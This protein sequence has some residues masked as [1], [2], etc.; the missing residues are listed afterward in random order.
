MQ[1]KY[2]TARNQFQPSDSSDSTQFN[3][4]LAVEQ[5]P[6]THKN[7]QHY[8]QQHEKMKEYTSRD[9][10]PIC[11][12]THWCRHSP[13]AELRVIHCH[14]GAE[15]GY[16]IGQTYN[17]DGVERITRAHSSHGVL[18]FIKDGN[19]DQYYEKYKKQE[20]SM[21][22]S[23]RQKTVHEESFSAIH[24][25]NIVT[26]CQQVE[27]TE[28]ELDWAQRQ[29]GLTEADLRFSKAYPNN[30]NTIKIANDYLQQHQD[31]L[32]NSNV[33]LP[34]TIRNSKKVK[35]Y[36][37]QHGI[38]FPSFTA[39][40][41]VQSFQIRAFNPKTKDRKYEAAIHSSQ[42][43]YSVYHNNNGWLDKVAYTEGPAKALWMLKMGYKVVVALQGKGQVHAA[44]WAAA[45]VENLYG[46]SDSVIALDREDNDKSDNN[47]RKAE[48]KLAIQLSFL[49]QVS[50]LKWDNI[51]GKGI[52][53]LMRNG[54]TH[55]VEPFLRDPEDTTKALDGIQK[56]LGMRLVKQ[57]ESHH[58]FDVDRARAMQNHYFDTIARPN[59]DMEG[60]Y[61]FR[62]GAGLGKTDQLIA[63]VKY[64]IQNTDKRISVMLGDKQ[65]MAEFA[66]KARKMWGSET[67]SLFASIQLYTGRDVNN[68]GEKDQDGRNEWYTNNVEP[69]QQA[70]RSV[71]RYVCKECPFRQQCE[72]TG[73]YAQKEAA[74]QAQVVISTHTSAKFLHGFDRG[75]GEFDAIYFDENPLGALLQTQNWTRTRIEGMASYIRKIVEKHGDKDAKR[76]EEAENDGIEQADIDVLDELTR[77]QLNNLQR[78]LE[79]LSQM[80]KDLGDSANYAEFFSDRDFIKQ[81][82][83]TATIYGKITPKDLLRTWELI[84]QHKNDHTHEVS[85][86]ESDITKQYGIYN[87]FR[88]LIQAQNKTPHSRFR[89]YMLKQGDDVK[90]TVGIRNDDLI[91]TLN[92]RSI[93]LDASANIAMYSKI[94]KNFRYEEIHPIMKNRDSEIIHAK[95]L[96]SAQAMKKDNE[97]VELL[98]E[99]VEFTGDKTNAA[100]ISILDMKKKIEKDP[101]FSDFLTAYYGGDARGTNRLENEKIY[102]VT[103]YAMNVLAKAVEF[104]TLTG[105]SFSF[106]EETEDIFDPINSVMKK[107]K[108]SG[109]KEFDEYYLAEVRAEIYQAI[110]RSRINTRDDAV[111]IYYLGS[112][113]YWPTELPPLKLKSN[114]VPAKRAT[115]T[116]TVNEQK[117]AGE[118]ENKIRIAMELVKFADVEQDQSGIKVNT[119][120]Y[121]DQVLESAG[122]I[123]KFSRDYAE[124][125]G[126]SA[127]TVRRTIKDED[128][129]NEY[130]HEALKTVKFD[131]VP[132]TIL[133]YTSTYNS[134]RIA[135]FALL[136]VFYL[137][138]NEITDQYSVP[139]DEQQK[140]A[141]RVDEI[142]PI[143]WIPDQ[144]IR[145]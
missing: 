69:I 9:R 29:W 132:L 63:L 27:F 91:H 65:K 45:D 82:F 3:G 62:F 129:V 141:N 24:L 131:D 55:R 78:I 117:Q 49:G 70:G 99:L 108:V 143:G 40:E 139:V 95:F 12:K 44:A 115:R 106:S 11:G 67:D 73:Y 37:T 110:M 105:E 136:K 81:L 120:D 61:L 35:W 36:N 42:A 93:V 104:Q 107:K 125:L 112:A 4:M 28:E 25:G 114:F 39:Y 90:F 109:Y 20:I 26:Q 121:I 17:I 46:L 10:C 48:E 47:T 31:E 122:G 97:A 87:L 60:L 135:I 41:T 140:M 50:I 68:C 113:L 137:L 103:G 53:D 66:E 38:V 58:T 138:E 123:M 94:F 77:A 100:I 126:C 80:L 71:S 89:I 19:E 13:D 22:Y 96:T 76:N 101:Y 14:W 8:K 85:L 23:D 59:V 88:A 32:L 130:F 1:H 54:K 5:N 74:K 142:L 83:K 75:L 30:Q 21:I 124:I 6:L 15:N 86:L 119:F 118:Y 128:F 116:D 34:G 51:D 52:D 127:E 133:K 64:T 43:G 84:D 56:A 7:Y 98:R 102:Y 33:D 92:Q 72:L 79:A 16:E 57:T 134:M 145:A 2:S 111:R 144:R 18:F